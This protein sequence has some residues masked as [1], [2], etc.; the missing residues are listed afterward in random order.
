MSGE[1]D[2]HPHTSVHVC[3]CYEAHTHARTHIRSQPENLLLASKAHGANVKLADFGLAVEA[4]DGKHYYGGWSLRTVNGSEPERAPHFITP[5]MW[6]KNNCMVHITSKI[7]VPH[8]IAT[9]FK[10]CLNSPHSAMHCSVAA[11][12]CSSDRMPRGPPLPRGHIT[13]SLTTLTK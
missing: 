4:M 12:S 1:T 10:L 6:C 11:P 3:N 13:C 8:L 2:F 9:T 5:R 7:R